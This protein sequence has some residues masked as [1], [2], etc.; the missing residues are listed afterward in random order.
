MLHTT[1]MLNQ[2]TWIESCQLE[3]L[4]LVCKYLQLPGFNNNRGIDWRWQCLVYIA[5][6]NIL[7]AMSNPLWSGFSQYDA[8]ESINTPRID[9]G[10]VTLSTIW[11]CCWQNGK[12][13][14]SE[15]NVLTH[16]SQMTLIYYNGLQIMAESAKLVSP[17][18]LTDEKVGGTVK[19]MGGP[20]TL[21]YMTM[22]KIGKSCKK[23]IF[24]L[25]KHEK[26]SQCLIMAC[27]LDSVKPQSEPMLEYC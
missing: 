5:S 20:I 16:W 19:N 27:C 10:L 21:L 8:C 13:F 4:Q 22:F 7:L 3:I 14:C 17:R 18:S 11:K 15:L 9:C 23:L 1:S 24:D 2:V 12:P 25:V 26:F 6:V